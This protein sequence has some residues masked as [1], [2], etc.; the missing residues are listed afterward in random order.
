MKDLCEFAY[1]TCLQL[2]R[3]ANR[4][5]HPTGG[6]CA[7]PSKFSD[8]LAELDL[9]ASGISRSENRIH[10][11]KGVYTL[12]LLNEI[13]APNTMMMFYYSAQIHLRKL[14]NRVHTDLYKVEPNKSVS[15]DS[16]HI[17]SP[18]AMNRITNA[19]YMCLEAGISNQFSSRLVAVLSMNLDMWRRSLPETMKWEDSEPPANNII[20]ARLRA[21]YY[22]AAYIIHRPLLYYAL[23]DMCPP[24]GLL[25]ATESPQYSS[26][27]LSS[28]SQQVS[29]PVSQNQESTWTFETLPKH[30][31]RSCKVCIKSAIQSTTAFDGIEGRPIVTNIFGTAHA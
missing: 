2:E 24:Q 9:P 26:S 10:L 29:P 25:A 21:K 17:C 30:V 19:N 14:L 28:Q 11:P 13:K 15:S 23:H 12:S 7:N 16:K 20:I 31:Q 27:Q 8:I 6:R 18:V 1:W 4:C 22:G 5:T 3:Y